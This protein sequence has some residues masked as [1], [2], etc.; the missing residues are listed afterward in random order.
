MP[1]LQPCF[2]GLCARRCYPAQSSTFLSGFGEA[3]SLQQ[4]AFLYHGEASVAFVVFFE[5]DLELVNEV[6]VALGTWC[7]RMV[8]GR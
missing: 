2:H 6:L 8:R 7:L 3:G 1:P 4:M 5:H